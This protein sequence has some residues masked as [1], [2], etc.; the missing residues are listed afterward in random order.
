MSHGDA[1]LPL[2]GHLALPV[3]EKNW[4]REF[5]DIFSLL[6]KLSQPIMKLGDLAPDPQVVK[7]IKK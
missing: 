4:R 2:G 5:V 7:K 1:A 3:K 6:H